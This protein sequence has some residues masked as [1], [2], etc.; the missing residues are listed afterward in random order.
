MIPLHTYIY[1]FF[2]NEP[3]EK[4]DNPVPSPQAELHT[5][6]RPS[7]R[8]GDL[9]TGSGDLGLGALWGQGGHSPTGPGGRKPKQLGRLGNAWSRTAGSTC[10]SGGP[11]EGRA[12]QGP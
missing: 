8:G 9:V 4:P 6:V 3:P 7:G 5:A 11:A 2:T 12:S 10:W 1:S